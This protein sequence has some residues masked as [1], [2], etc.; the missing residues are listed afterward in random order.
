MKP[1]ASIQ[2]PATHHAHMQLPRS[3]PS[4][5]A[6]SHVISLDHVQPQG[7]HLHALLGGELALHAVCQDEVGPDVEAFE[8]ALARSAG[9][10][11]RGQPRH[12][13]DGAVTVVTVV[14]EGLQNVND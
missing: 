1:Q 4:D 3:Q 7:N 2:T 8:L 13:G 12:N 11:G 10:R 6:H 9:Y 14:T 5:R